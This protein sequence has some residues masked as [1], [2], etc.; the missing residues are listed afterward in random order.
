MIAIGLGFIVTKNENL[1]IFGLING[2]DNN[3]PLATVKGAQS[4]FVAA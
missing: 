2:K 3:T 4:D 1:D